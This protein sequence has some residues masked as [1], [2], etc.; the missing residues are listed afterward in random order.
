MKTSRKIAC[1][2]LLGLTLVTVSAC[3]DE[4]HGTGTVVQKIHRPAYLTM[5]P[6][7]T[8]KVVTIVPISEP[9]RWEIDIQDSGQSIHAFDFDKSTFDSTSIGSKLI[10]PEKK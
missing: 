3:G 9:E 7:S 4:W 6:I 8:G 1:A 2:S 10:I 5:M